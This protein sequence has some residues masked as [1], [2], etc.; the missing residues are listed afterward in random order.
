MADDDR[1]EPQLGAIGRRTPRPATQLKS[2]AKLSRWR[3]P[4]TFGRKKLTAGTVVRNGRG[5]GAAVVARHWA[6]PHRR[7]AF[8]AVSIAPARGANRSAY[9]SHIEYIRRDHT[10]AEG[11][12]SPVFDRDQTELPV[13]D[14]K[15]RSARDDHQFRITLSPVDAGELADLTG[16]TR[17]LMKQVERDL[18]VDTDWI[19][20]AHYNS[21]HPHVHI[22]VRGKNEQEGILYIDRKYIVF[23][24]RHRAEELLTQELGRQSWREQS[25]CRR[26]EVIAERLTSIDWEL[27]R[28]SKDG[29]IDLGADKDA[30]SGH[31]WS[32][33]VAR[34]ETLR[35]LGIARHVYGSHWQLA[36]GWTDTLKALGD[37]TFAINQLKQD[38]SYMGVRPRALQ[39]AVS[40][41]GTWITGRLMSRVSHPTSVGAET[42]LI[43]GTDGRLWVW[44][45]ASH[46]ADQL[47]SPGAIV[48][49]EVPPAHPRED[50]ERAVQAG[51]DPQSASG[52]IRLFV[53]SWISLDAMIERRAFTW[54]DGVSEASLEGQATGFGEEVR[55]A[56]T[57]RLNY[58]LRAPIDWAES[59]QLHTQERLSAAGVIALRLQKR[60]TERQAREV[61]NG[62]Y[63]ENVETAHGRYAVIAGKTRF[64]LVPATS[65][66]A[67]LR[68]RP[69][70]IEPGMDR[71]LDAA[72]PTRSRTRI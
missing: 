22:V 43:D 42:I 9:F 27:Y 54:L 4:R 26:H 24:L 40:A 12:R 47:P 60:Y 16:F 62:D 10:A 50:P 53:H 63:L 15:R 1:F 8:V 59:E 46:E 34:L 6:D 38:L 13:D 20:A 44:R 5:R 23:G 33:K 30:R 67:H 64:T 68:G 17:K 11:S 49:I 19:A 37:R 32:R 25:P 31:A 57:A 61:F 70:T 58:L 3:K 66:M 69:V 14:F 48:S 45:A 21:A 36:H 51:R 52:R 18:G 72:A 41:P 56:R 2:L 7:R 39:D 35:R 71:I 65:D 29:R 55:A 28:E